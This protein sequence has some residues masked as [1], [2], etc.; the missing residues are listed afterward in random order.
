MEQRGPD[1]LVWIDRRKNVIKLSQGEYVSVSRLEALFAG[2][3]DV[4][5]VGGLVWRL[6][7]S[8]K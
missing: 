6:V 5:Q 1:V 3:H 8:F 2:H 4:Q 7:G